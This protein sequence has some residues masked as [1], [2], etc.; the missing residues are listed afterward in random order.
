MYCEIHQPDGGKK[1]IHCAMISVDES[2]INQIDNSNKNISVS[3][4]NINI[5]S[6]DSNKKSG[7][8]N[9]NPELFFYQFHK[10]DNGYLYIDDDNDGY[11]TNIN[12]LNVFKS[13]NILEKD[14]NVYVKAFFSILAN[15]DNIIKSYQLKKECINIAIYNALFYI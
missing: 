6:L 4:N 7:Y 2:D 9:V 3:N 15:E 13:C 1:C 14:A 8:F 10:K 5:A 11:V 12:F